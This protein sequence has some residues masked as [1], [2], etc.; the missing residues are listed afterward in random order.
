[1]IDVAT[2]NNHILHS[3]IIE[4]LQKRTDLEEEQEYVWQLYAVYIVPLRLS[5]M[6]T[7]PQKLQD[8]LTLLNLRSSLHILIQNLI[9]NTRRLE[10][11][12]QNNKQA[13]FLISNFRRFLNIVCILLGRQITI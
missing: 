10:S 2:P 9:V 4:K 12:Q 7:V 8:S 11:F 1:L 5:T 6:G 3:T 13:V